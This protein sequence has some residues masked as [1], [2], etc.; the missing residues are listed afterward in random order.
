MKKC[1]SC[2]KEIDSKAKKCPFCQTDQRGWFAK[3]PILTGL[4]VLIVIGLIASASGGNKGSSSNSTNPGNNANVQTA[5]KPTAGV[6]PTPIIMDAT[7]LVGEYDKNK[8]SAQDKYTGKV[9]QT[10]GYIKNISN[11]ITGE[12]YLSLNPNNDQYYFG[13]TISCYFQSK[14]ELTSLSN[15]QSVTVMGTMQDM[16]LG[17]VNMK[18]CSLVK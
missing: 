3:H 10:T 6:K 11:D 15:G 4:L 2:Q 1:K 16:S 14:S 18:D 8:L 17:I 13:T 9:I 7:S 12:Y 5:S